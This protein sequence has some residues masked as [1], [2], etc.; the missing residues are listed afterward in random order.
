MKK[1]LLAARERL[2]SFVSSVFHRT[3]EGR[4]TK[5][6]EGAILPGSLP[7]APETEEVAPPSPKRRKPGW[8][9]DSYV[10]AEKEGHARFH[11]FPVSLKVMR[12]VAD[13]G[14]QYCTPVQ[15]QSLSDCLAGSD[16]VAKANT[17]TGKTAVF[18]ITIITRLLQG[19]RGRPGQV[20]ALVLA[21]TRELVIQIG[22]DARQLAKYSNFSVRCVFGGTDYQKQQDILREKP[23]DLL[24][25]TPGRLLDFL[26]KN[27]V[28]LD[29]CQILVL[30]E[31]D[32]MLDMG[33]IP[34]VRRIVGR[35]PAA[36]ARQTLLFSATVTDEVRRLAHQWCIE[37]KMV[38]AE[39][40]QVATESVRQVVYLAS[41]EE[42]YIVLCNLIGQ[43]PDQR[44]I[45][46]TNMKGEARRLSDR[47][48]RQGISSVLL[49]GDVPQ[50]KR[51]TRLE[52]FRS[53]ETKVLVATDVAGR[54]IHIEGIEVVV[55][56]SLPYEP[57]DYVHRIGRTGRA[58]ADGLAVS[59]ACE[60][61]AFY[62][63][64]IEELLGEKFECVLPEEELLQPLPP[65][66]NRVVKKG[67]DH[68]SKGLHEK[69]K[70]RPRKRTSSRRGS[71]GQ[72]GGKNGKTV[73]NPD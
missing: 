10:V 73:K 51:M 50:Q 58:G 42:K 22:K 17:G 16:L 38:E 53:G 54:G 45:V 32:R 46:F 67:K 37:P 44:I 62:L 9:L 35:L 12:A 36:G 8:T 48:Q 18:L 70:R 65:A 57:E 52:R 28:R 56:F 25:A 49:S 61:G 15:Q 26:G 21:P 40:E 55:N 68:N 29:C 14:F 41:V 11:D 39:P 19:K 23:C 64:A 2:L 6:E 7:A 33:F 59:F 43:R 31:A 72:E 69:R 66:K 71:S 63:P 20:R 4:Q 5:Q 30:D 27:I 1:T 47:L 34:D 3:R 13:L 60:E 24:V